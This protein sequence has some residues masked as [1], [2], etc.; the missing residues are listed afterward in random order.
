MTTTDDCADI[1]A[2]LAALEP[3]DWYIVDDRVY[4]RQHGIIA[5]CYL[6]G[7][8]ADLIANAPRDL[9][10]L[11]D[12]VRE[13]EALVSPPSLTAIYE[14]ETR[15]FD[16]TMAIYEAEGRCPCGDLPPCNLHRDKPT[17][18]E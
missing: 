15:L 1:E 11:L 9:R 8:D 3:A 12:R 7:A 6:Q 17:P 2:R 10:R 5:D 16:A 18:T 14:A 13:L 4:D